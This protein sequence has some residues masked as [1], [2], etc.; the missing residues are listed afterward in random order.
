MKRKITAVLLC[1]ALIVSVTP[2]VYAQNTTDDTP[3]I[4]T[5]NENAVQTAREPYIVGEIIEKRTE[6]TKHF[7]MSDRSI[8]AAIYNQSVHY[9][10]GSSWLDIDN[11]FSS[12]DGNEYENK[13]NSFKTKF[14]KKSNGNKLV[15]IT[16]DNYSLSWML[17]NAN[18][19]NAQISPSNETKIEDIS[20]LKNIQGAVTY[21]DVQNDTDLQYVV[22]GNDVKEN[23]ILQSAAAPTEYSFTYKFNDLKYRTNENNQIEFYNESS[24]ENIVFIID[25]PYMYDSANAYSNNIE[26]QISETSNGFK[27]TL[28]PNK[29]WL[30]SEDRVYPIVIDPTT[31]SSQKA[32]NVWDI[33]LQSTQTQALNYAAYDFLVGSDT[34]G[35]KYRTMLKISNLPSIGVGGIV[36]NA[37][38]YFHRYGLL[39]NP[40]TTMPAFRPRPTDDIQVNIHRIN[41]LWPEQGAVWNN[42]AERYDSIIEDYFIYNDTDDQ[43]NADITNLVNDWYKGA[44]NYGIM[45]KAASEA[46]ANHVMQ[47]ASSDFAT[48]ESSQYRGVRPYLTVNYRTCIGLEDYWSY[49]TQDMGGYGT[50]YVNNYNGN[51]TYV[52]SD[53]S[54]NSLI[55]GFTLSHVYNTANSVNST[56]RY[57]KGWGLS[58]V[59]RIDPVAIKDTN[60]QYVYTDGDGTKHYFIELNDGTIVDEDGLGYTF[61][62][63]NEGELIYKLTDKDKNVLKFDQWGALRRIIDTNGN[64]INLNYSPVPNQFNYL[65]SITTSSGGVFALK[66]D[67]NYV[68]TSITDNAGRVTRFEYDSGNLTKITYPDSTYVEYSYSGNKL[69]QITLPDRKKVCYFYYPNSKISAQNIKSASNNMTAQYCFNYYNNKT[70]IIDLVARKSTYQFD[71]FG[72]VTCAYD[73]QGNSYSESYVSEAEAKTNRFKSNKLNTTSNNIRNINN[74]ITNPSFADG[75]SS[76]S[77]YKEAPGETEISV[78]SDQSYVSSKSVK[79]SS[80]ASSIQAL[81]QAPSTTAGKTYTLSANIKTENVISATHGA[82]VEIVKS[83]PNGNSSFVGDLITGTTDP[84]INNGF[85]TV[86]TT[87]SLAS[88]ENIAR[89]GVGLYNASGTMWIDSVQLEEGDTANKINLLSNSSFEKNTGSSALPTGYT[90]N[91]TAGA[92]G[93]STSADKHSGSYSLKISGSATVKRYAYQTLN[94]S[95]KAGDVY[96]MG[97]WAR[98][99]AVANHSSNGVTD[100][101]L[102]AGVYYTNGDYVEFPFDLNEYT[103]DWQYVF[104][105]FVMKN[106]Y[107]KILIYCSY[108]YN[109]NTAYFD[110]MFLY[111]DTAQSYEY[112]ENGNVVSTADYA[113]QQSTFEYS[114]NYLSK[115][116][117]PTGTKYTYKYDDEKNL[118]NASSNVGIDYNIAYDNYG[119]ATQT[120]IVS[121]GDSEIDQYGGVYYIKN[122]SS[123]QYLTVSGGECVRANINQQPLTNAPLQRWRVKKLSNGNY[124]MRPDGC[125]EHAL[126]FES[127]GVVNTTVLLG[128]TGADVETYDWS[129]WSL[130][131]NNDEEHSF[132]IKTMATNCV[133]KFISIATSDTTN[134]GNI[135]MDYDGSTDNKSWIFIPANEIITSS[136]TYQNNGNFPHTVT[137]SLGNTTTYTYDTARGLQTGITDANGNTTEYEYNSLNDRLDMVVSGGSTVEYNYNSIGQLTGIDSPSGTSY[138]LNY[139]EFG[140]TKTI[141]V[142]SQKLTENFYD[143]NR[144]LLD[145]S[146]YGNNYRI[147]YNYD[148]LDRVTEKLY[149]N[150]A[151]VKFRYDKFGNLYEKQDLFTNTTY[152]YNYDLSGRITGITGSDNTSLNYVYDEFNRVE[153]YVAK[154]GSNSNTTEYIYGDSSVEGQKNGLVYGVKQNDT[155]RLSY[156]YDHF[157][158]LYTKTINTTTPFEYEYIYERDYDQGITSTQLAHMIVGY[159]THNYSYDSVGNI[160]QYNVNGTNL[161]VY[162]YDANNQLKTETRDGDVYEYTYDNGGNIQSVTKNGQSYKSYTYGNSEWRDLLTVFNGD[163]ITYDSIGNPLQYRDSFEFTWSNGRQLTS[164]HE[165]D[166]HLTTTYTYNADGLRTSKNQYGIDE[167]QYYWLDGVLICE[168]TGNKYTIFLYDENGTPY[169]FVINNKYYYYIQNAQGDIIGIL[170]ADGNIIAKYKYDAWGNILS[171]TDS[172]NNKIVNGGHIAHKNPLRYRG[173]YYDSETGFYYLQ[174]RYYDPITCRFINAD[175]LIDNRGIITQNLFQYC[176]NN[177]VNNADP[178]GNLFGAIV[179]IGLLVIG[180]VATLSGCSSKPAATTSTPSTP[181]KPSTPSSSTSSTTPPHIPTP[182]EKSYAATVYAEAGGQNKRSKQ[183]VAHVMNN[184]IGTRSSWTDIEAVI[185]APYQFEGYNSPMYRAAMDYYDKGICDNSI[186]RSAM[187]ECLAVVIPIYSGAEADITGG[188]LYFHSFPNPS[189]WPYHNSLTQVY[190]SGTEKFWFYK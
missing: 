144:G 120:T 2:V 122:K 131:A 7:L 143:T 79:I 24:P 30:L 47:F 42:Y 110:D 28:I 157:A 188:A 31:L 126:A 181:S 57:G 50:G 17:D 101:K 164:V 149:N 113:K 25:T 139:D 37:K 96:S 176:G 167:T 61:S 128:V 118:V 46:A 23:I 115:T 20:A 121:G 123:G 186:D 173:Y 3:P 33:T 163:T 182:Q 147:D 185:S 75:L 174:S 43:F 99:N 141:Y 178:S 63:I 38:V 129:Q 39:E 150:V 82:T 134:G 41:E 76:W 35:Q 53:V 159:D 10:D 127:R 166:Y 60:V 135:Y 86:R 133:T 106:D 130:I 180:M 6:D 183:A 160:V 94:L 34:S 184:R 156:A 93:G 45:L 1:V 36:V 80:T 78:V 148:L 172:N 125:N 107:N 55:N 13:S 98:A 5:K 175:S 170:D 16:K 165:S 105:N 154:F 4:V 68:L 119:N 65:S 40:Q 169:G 140:N 162:T 12:N 44:N 187:D 70:E 92:A 116:V 171:I 54:F 155:Q 97:G 26:M 102:T 111:R 114:D 14:S 132:K 168:K 56:G 91:F 81:L 109:A 58:L 67:S 161:G 83:T 104:G 100:F 64:T 158:R 152:R 29:D 146:V 72:R 66:Y 190:V 62:S 27:L 21:P 73:S 48:Y 95:G 124:I 145:Y 85:V 142:G 189:D 52:H 59:Q 11:S 71:S 112:D 90:A 87:V 151:K 22:S 138:T 103:T 74:Y 9:N 18:K 84:E 49:T 108:N 8:M 19:V 177:P 136:A 15:T 77:Q 117:E 179:G 153:K 51:L 32:T 137:D 89:I 88:D 69:C